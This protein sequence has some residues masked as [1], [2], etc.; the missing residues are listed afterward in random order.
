MPKMSNGIVSKCCWW[1]HNKYLVLGG[2]IIALVLK[3]KELAE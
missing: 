1:L 3:Y 2:I